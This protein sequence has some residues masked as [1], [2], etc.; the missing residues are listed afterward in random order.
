MGDMAREC[1][2]LHVD[3]VQDGKPIFYLEQQAEKADLST[4]M[5]ECRL[6][7]RGSPT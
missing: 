4:K 2:T 5:K 3:C 1:A 7:H 6:L